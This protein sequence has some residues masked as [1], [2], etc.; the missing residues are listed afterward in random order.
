MVALDMQPMSVV[1][2]EG[3]K[4]L[5]SFLEPD[6]TMPCRK[7]VTSRVIKLYKDCS[8]KIKRLLDQTMYVALTTDCWTSLTMTS[9]MAVTCHYIDQ[10]WQMQAHVLT[11][12]NIE[13]RHTAENL[14]MEL[15]TVVAEWRVSG[16]VSL[17][18]HDNAA[19]IVKANQ[20]CDWE[21]VC[22]FA[23]TLQLAIN[24]GFKAVQILERMIGACS[25]LVAHFH[26]STT[27]TQVLAVK[28]KQMSVK[29]HALIQCCQTRWNSI[30]GMFERLTEQRW[31]VCA[32]LSDRSV[33]KPVDA[34]NLELKDEYWRLMEEMDP[35]LKALAMA[36]T[37][38]CGEEAVS[39]SV[40]YPMVCGL[41][42]EHLQPSGG[43]DKFATFVNT[44]RESLAKRFLPWDTLT[45][46]KPAV[47]AAVLDPR[48]KN[49]RFLSPDI[50]AAAKT[51]MEAIF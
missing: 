39:I 49:L 22:C 19:N 33:T 29:E 6:Y 26:H 23:H 45:A 40:V 30:Y 1:E 51:H 47:V 20:A 15:E 31:A 17:C 46:S 27:A 12:Q 21:S 42:N 41:M 25:K 43:N 5:I 10:E 9:Y 28:Q 7:T 13:A 37:A 24:D 2:D 50:Q 35:V 38:T 11:T 18:V 16:R 34:R 32:V 48:H 4:K 8:A 3:F 14:Q 44:V 36:T